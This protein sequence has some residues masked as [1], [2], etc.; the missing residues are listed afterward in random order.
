MRVLFLFQRF[1]LA[2][3]TL[4]DGKNRKEAKKAKQTSAKMSRNFVMLF[5]VYT[6]KNQFKN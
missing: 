6:F 2:G 5:R 3:E 1:Y 4:G